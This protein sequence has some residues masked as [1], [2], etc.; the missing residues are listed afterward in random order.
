MYI[1]SPYRI[2]LGGGVM[3]QEHLF[4]RIR[5]RVQNLLNGYLH[6]VA[7][8]E[9]ITSFIVPPKLGS[10]AGMLGALELARL[11]EAKHTT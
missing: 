7:I 2:I 3:L 9:D 1:T 11:A 4:P 10:R 6:H 8:L 5:H